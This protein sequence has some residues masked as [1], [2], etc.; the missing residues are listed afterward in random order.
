M[1]KKNTKEHKDFLV[2]RIQDDLDNYKEWK[3][4]ADNPLDFD[5][6]TAIANR[7]LKWLKEGVKPSQVEAT[8]IKVLNTLKITKEFI[9]DLKE[10]SSQQ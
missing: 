10:I 8:Y 5:A 9:E 7:C 6:E 3:E 1:A 2:N 4:L